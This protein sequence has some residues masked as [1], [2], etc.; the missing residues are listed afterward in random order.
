MKKK[1]IKLLLLF[2]ILFTVS[3]AA[4]AQI[5]V[6][7]RPVAPVVIRTAQPRSDNVWVDEEWHQRRGN[8]SY[9]GGHWERPPHRGYVRKSGYWKRTDRGEIWIQGTWRRG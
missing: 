7:I 2:V 6:K 1:L 5:Y 4:S 8:Y 9:A 3:F